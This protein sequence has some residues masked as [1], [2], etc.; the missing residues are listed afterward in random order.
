MLNR[1]A[2]DLWSERKRSASKEADAESKLAETARKQAD[3]QYTQ[4]RTQALD[5]AERLDDARAAQM[6][7]EIEQQDFENNMQQNAASTAVDQQ[8]ERLI[9]AI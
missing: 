4:R 5:A 9:D 2:L 8:I 7:S 3:T 6:L 1:R